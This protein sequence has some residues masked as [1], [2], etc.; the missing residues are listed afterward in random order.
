MAESK[1]E[2]RINPTL[3]TELRETASEL[4][5]SYTVWRLAEDI[6]ENYAAERRMRSLQNRAPI[7]FIARSNTRE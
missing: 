7:A 1:L 4:G 6:L 3:L 5:G 2:L